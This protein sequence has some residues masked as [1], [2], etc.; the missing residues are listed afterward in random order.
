MGK[1]S[2]SRILGLAYFTFEKIN[3]LHGKGPVGKFFSEESLTGINSNL[4]LKV[5][6]SIFLFL[7]KILNLKFYQ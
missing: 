3:Q 7:A 5:K 6:D 4:M 2:R 1:R